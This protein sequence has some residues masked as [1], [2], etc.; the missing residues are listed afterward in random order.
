[1]LYP[2]EIRCGIPQGSNLGPLLFRIYVNDLPY[3]LKHSTPRLFADDTT[4][5][6]AATNIKEIEKYS[7]LDLSNLSEWFLAN[8]QSLNPKKTVYMLMASNLKLS[9]ICYSPKLRILDSSIKRV[10]TTK[11]LGA[12]IDKRPSWSD[13]VVHYKESFFNYSRHNKYRAF[14]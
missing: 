7:N 4:I 12:H 6:V 13:H 3:C 11:S 14:C 1:M 9:N 2:C 5:T 8:K 10:N